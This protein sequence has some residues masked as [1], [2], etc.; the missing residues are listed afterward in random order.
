MA[1]GGKTVPGG[2]FI[3]FEGCE[4]AGKTTQ[5]RLLGD[6]LRGE[7]YDTVV[8][9]EPGDTPA[10][11]V[12]REL[13]L[14]PGM[15]L[16]AGTEALLFAADRCQ[17]V[18]QVIRPAMGRG[19]IVV[20]DRYADSSVAYQGYGRR[21][22]PSRIRELSDWAS[23]GL[24]PDLTV[25]LTT[26]PDEGRARLAGS[27]D[28]IERESPEFHRDVYQGFLNQ[29]RWRGRYL[30]VQGSRTP[31]QVHGYVRRAVQRLT[32]QADGAYFFRDDQ[33]EKADDQAAD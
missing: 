33:E 22:G 23:G 16:E 10:G 7:G 1:D 21:L 4:G 5:A 12:I 6:W 28:R 17:H 19:A 15:K 25:L 24:E 9:R 11:A 29:A 30:M 13:L 27:P 31:E 18:A 2:L 20:C 14:Y 3:V 32:G 26:D 8:T